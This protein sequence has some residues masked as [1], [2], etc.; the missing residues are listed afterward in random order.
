MW[1]DPELRKLIERKG[2]EL[3]TFEQAVKALKMPQ[4]NR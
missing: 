1:T 4:Q 3:L 2:I